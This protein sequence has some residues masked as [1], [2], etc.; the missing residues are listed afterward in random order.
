MP[1]FFAKDGSIDYEANEK[2]ADIMIAKGVDGFAYFGTTGEIFALTHEEKKEFIK[3]MTKY[4]D[5]RVNVIWGTG[6]TCFSETVDLSLTAQAAGADA[7]LVINPYYAV[8]E[9]KY[10][11]A[12]YDALLDAIEIP[13][14][15]YNI[16]SVSGYAFPVPL[17]ERLAKKHANLIGIKETIDSLEHAKAAVAIKK[18]RPDFRVFAARENLL[19]QSLEAGVDGFICAIGVWAPELAVGMQKSFREGD[20]DA[21]RVYAG[22]FL[23]AMECFDYVT[24]L[25][26]A[27]KNACYERFFPGREFG[28]RLP[29]L[30]MDA[31]GRQKIRELI[32]RIGLA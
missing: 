18:T 30:P 28:E 19:L 23:E 21:A 11:E 20:K 26:V 25:Y 2:Y 4:V 1:T 7:V 8:C 31:E 3:H 6:T 27:C 22:K 10:V 14:I 15:I 5:H 13:L 9:D 17:V 29:I 12:Y 24:P 32:A 16:P